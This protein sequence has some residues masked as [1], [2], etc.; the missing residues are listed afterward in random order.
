MLIRLKSSSFNFEEADPEGDDILFTKADGT[1]LPF[2]IE[3]WDNLTED[4]VIWVKLDTISDN[5]TDYFIV[6]KWG[7]TEEN[8]SNGAAVFDTANG[9][10]G[11]HLN[12]NHPYRFLKNRTGNRYHGTAD[13]A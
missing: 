1:A 10:A 9:F 5:S 11:G 6:M 8:R 12:E 13:S 7:G 4:A 3:Q 2:E